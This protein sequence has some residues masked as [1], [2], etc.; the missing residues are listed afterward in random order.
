TVTARWRAGCAF[1]AGAR[2]LSHHA[3]HAARPVARRRDLVLEEAARGRPAVAR[4]LIA[5]R[6]AATVGFAGRLAG[7]AGRIR[8][9][10]HALVVPAD[11]VDRD[12]GRPAPRRHHAGAAHARHAAR[13][14]DAARDARLQPADRRAVRG[15]IGEAPGAA[16]RLML[17]PQRT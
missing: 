6:P 1:G 16:A 7:E 9:D 15:R 3:R 12:L 17:A 2:M 8:R 4:A 10:L 5:P 14:V 13:L 11:P